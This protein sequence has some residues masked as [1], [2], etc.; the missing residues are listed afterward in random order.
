MDTSVPQ[1]EPL[2]TADEEVALALQIEAGILAAAALDRGERPHG[3]TVEELGWLVAAGARARRRYVEANLRLVSMVAHQAGQRV[4]L[5]D[6]DLFQ[7]GCLGLMTAV[8][9]YDC[10]RGSRFATYGLLWIRAFTGAASARLL[11]SLNLPTSRATQLRHARGI[12]AVLA[13]ELGR[14]PTAGEVA[15]A[16]GRSTDWTSRLLTHER[17]QGLDEV[18]DIAADDPGL[19]EVLGERVAPV[20][21]IG[22][23]EGFERRV[24]ELRLGFGGDPLTYAEVAR[25]LGVTGNRVRRAERRALERLREVCPQGERERLAG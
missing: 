11:G 3:A 4:G 9:R 6:A 25:Q 2:L 22:L 17:P 15:T 14:L 5:P 7:E 8:D 10:R 23:V 13:Q 21:L 24:L 1:A 16:L 20:D 19:E 12:E 18:D